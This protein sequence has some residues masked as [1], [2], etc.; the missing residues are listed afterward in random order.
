LTFP[1]YSLYYSRYFRVLSRKVGS[2][3]PVR[4]LRTRFTVGGRL[5]PS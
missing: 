3:G 5:I 2:G 1:G 4:P